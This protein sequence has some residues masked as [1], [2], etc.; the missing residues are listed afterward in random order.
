LKGRQFST[1]ASDRVIG[2]SWRS[3]AGARRRQVTDGG[4]DAGRVRKDPVSV[5]AR[6]KVEHRFDVFHV[7]S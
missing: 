6:F 4:E 2:R 5:D 7:I 1:T 3:T